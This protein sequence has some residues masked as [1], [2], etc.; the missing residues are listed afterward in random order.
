MEELTKDWKKM[1]LSSKE[2]NKFDLSKKKKTQTYTLAAKFFTRRSVNIKAVAKTFRPLWRTKRKFEVSNAGDNIIL[3]AF[4]SEED[5][6]KVLLGEPWAFDRHLVVFQRYDMSSP[7]EKLLFHKVSFWVQIHNLPYSLLSSEV[8]SSLGETLGEVTLPKDHTEMRGG[9]FL[10]VRV[11]IDV[12]EPLCRGRRVKFDENEEGWVSFMYERLPNLCYWCGQLTH[13]DKD[14]SLWLRSRGSLA[15]SEQQ[16]GPWMRASQYN[17]MKKTVVEVQGYESVNAARKQSFGGITKGMDKE[18]GSQRMMTRTEEVA[19]VGSGSA[20]TGEGVTAGENQSLTDFTD[21]L[22][23]IDEAING[24]PGL[25]CLHVSQSEVNE[26]D[27]GKVIYMEVVENK[28]G[29]TDQ[30]DAEIKGSPCFQ[31]RMEQEESMQSGFQIGWVENNKA[32]KGRRSENKSKSTGI[33][34]GLNR[35]IQEAGPRAK[36]TW[37][38]INRPAMGKEEIIDHKE[39]P[40]RKNNM[41]ITEEG[42][43]QE[44]EKKVRLEK[45]TKDLS[46][47]LASEFGSAEVARQPRRVQ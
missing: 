30:T 47:P 25:Q 37:V 22:N 10:R 33:E 8:A 32:N 41:Q 14:C 20:V 5:I 2:D 39:G 21:T 24:N 46:L 11:A 27:K 15:P 19:N 18:K 31:K 26:A 45:D 12:S 23:A 28:A 43:V 7:I 6:E 42:L 36:G 29:V 17:P 13:D 16:F 4:E 40:K 35:P 1:S 9:N 44:N 34:L 38:R 3:F